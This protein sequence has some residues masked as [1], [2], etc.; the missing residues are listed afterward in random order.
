MARGFKTAAKFL[1]PI[2]ERGLERRLHRISVPTL[3][4]WGAEDRFA[5]PSYGTLFV[6]RIRGARLELIPNAG[7][8]IGAEQPDAYAKAVLQFGR[9]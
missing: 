5:Q 8:A 2:P 3:V 6:E 7:H 9:E 4:V 1:F